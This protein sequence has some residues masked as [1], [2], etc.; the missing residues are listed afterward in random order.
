[1][2]AL[3]AKDNGTEKPEQGGDRQVQGAENGPL[4]ASVLAAGQRPRDPVEDEAH[5]QDGE[6]EGGVVV[7]DVGDAGHGDEGQVVQDPANDGVD[8]GVVDLVD[9]GEG[10]FGVAALP[11]DEVPGYDDAEGG[12]GEGA[13][14]VHERVA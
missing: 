4:E 6:V 3:H 9:V 12:E 13:A 14:P 11:A 2:I 8:A 5:G 10:E 7:M 1:M